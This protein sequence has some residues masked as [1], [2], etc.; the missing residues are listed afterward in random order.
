V[1]VG[2]QTKLC[3]ATWQFLNATKT[4][5]KQLGKPINEKHLLLFPFI[6]IIW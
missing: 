3:H 5:E 2:V 4:N 6:F 1:Q